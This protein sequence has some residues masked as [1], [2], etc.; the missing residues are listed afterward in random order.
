MQNK[1]AVAES[2][3]EEISFD[4]NHTLQIKSAGD[5]PAS[6]NNGHNIYKQKVTCFI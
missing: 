3:V 4:V 6:S 5:Q 2:E 1:N